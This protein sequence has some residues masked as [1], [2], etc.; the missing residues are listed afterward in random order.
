MTKAQLKVPFNKEGNMLGYQYDG[1]IFEWKDNFEFK[2]ELCFECFMRGQSSAKA[3]FCSNLNKNKYFVFLT[4][5]DKIIKHG[6][7]E[8]GIIKGTFTFSKR[9]NNYGIKL[10]E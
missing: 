1:N 7:E 5:L 3:V 10:L 8:N 4:D 2:D 6:I 9:G